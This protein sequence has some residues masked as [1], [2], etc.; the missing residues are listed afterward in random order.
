MTPVHGTIL[1]THLTLAF[2][3]IMVLPVL[4]YP[5]FNGYDWSPW[6]S[7]GEFDRAVREHLNQELFWVELARP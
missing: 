4:T 6:N 2:N 1:Q 5:Y 3:S 7:I